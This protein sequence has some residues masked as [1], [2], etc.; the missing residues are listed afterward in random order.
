MNFG[1]WAL[2]LLFWTATKDIGGE[3]AL[4]DLYWLLNFQVLLT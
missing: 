4:W 3:K 2:Y 1:K